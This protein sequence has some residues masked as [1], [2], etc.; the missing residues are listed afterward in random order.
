MKTTGIVRQT[1][2]KSD[3]NKAFFALTLTKTPLI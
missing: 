2:G 3:K 1:R